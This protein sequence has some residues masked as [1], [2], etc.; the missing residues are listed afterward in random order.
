MKRY[1]KIKDGV[2]VQRQPRPAEGFIEAPDT[3]VCG[4][5]FDGENFTNPEPPAEQIAERKR[6]EKL[7]ALDAS[8]KD[9]ARIAED[10]I[11]ALIAKEL[12]SESDFPEAVRDKLQHRS[13]LR[14]AL[15]EKK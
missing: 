7:A 3:V 8:D 9:M 13:K 6:Q 1:V 5:L 15:K 10:V 14:E 11:A 12:L 2:V 4:M